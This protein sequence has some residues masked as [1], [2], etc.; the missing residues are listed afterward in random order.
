[1]SD[2]IQFDPHGFAFDFDD[3]T[4]KALVERLLSSP[5]KPLTL[6]IGPDRK[7]VYALFWKGK[8][9]YVGKA[10]SMLLRGRLNEHRN[11]IAKRDNISLNDMTCR[12]LIIEVDWLIWAAEATLISKLTP[13]W[14]ASGFGRH[15]QGGNRNDGPNRWDTEF[16]IR[17]QSP[18]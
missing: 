18:A 1:M 16:P 10:I 8:L 12:Y 7:G 5:A 13:D 9:V 2:E 6:S 4:H 14:N 11:K 15:V 3:E 17:K